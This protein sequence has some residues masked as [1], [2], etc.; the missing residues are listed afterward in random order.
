LVLVED[1]LDDGHEGIKLLSNRQ[2]FTIC[3]C[4]LSKR[5]RTCDTDPRERLVGQHV[6][7]GVQVPGVGPVFTAVARGVVKGRAYAR[8]EVVVVCVVRRRMPGDHDP[9]R[10]AAVHCKGWQVR[11][12]R[13]PSERCT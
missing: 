13:V 3:A 5:K 1:G 8:L 4:S 12:R 2:G 6:A 7:L 9:R 11:G 10:L